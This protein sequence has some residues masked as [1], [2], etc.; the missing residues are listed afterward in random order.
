MLR[1]AELYAY[2]AEREA[3]RRRRAT[4][5]SPPWSDDPTLNI[6]KFTNVYRKYDRTSRILNEELYIPHR[7][8]PRAD[9]LFNAAVYRYFGTYE[10]ARAVGWLRPCE[11]ALAYVARKARQR[12]DD[13]ERVWTG[14]YMVRAETR[15]KN[16]PKEL[17][18]CDYIAGLLIAMEEIITCDD[19]GWRTTIERI[20]RVHGFGPFMA[21]EVVLDA[22]CASYWPS[23]PSDVNVWCPMGPGAVRGAARLIGKGDFRNGKFYADLSEP[24]ALGVCLSAYA[25]RRGYWPKEYEPLELHDIQWNLCEWDKYE[26]VRLDQGRPRSR[27]KPTLD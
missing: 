23:T 17:T 1:V 22:R 13:G 27:F 3:I 19:G 12:M 20:Q 8:A 15:A 14:A 21:K 11:E 26:R 9:I 25:K 24:E 18:V 10:F 4:G 7:G 5:L 6:Y 16:T 2:M